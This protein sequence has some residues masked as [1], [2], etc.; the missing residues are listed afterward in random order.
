VKR[1]IVV[2]LCLFAAAC[3][4]APTN[5]PTPTSTPS[6]A[7]VDESQAVRA[8]F[9][10]YT[11]AALA[12]DGTTAVSVMA[13]PAFAFFDDMRKLALTATEQELATQKLST[14]L[15]AYTMRGGMDP[16]IVRTA[17]PQDLV[18][19][20]IDKGLVGEQGI[21]NLELGEVTVKG[22]TADVEVMSR[23]KKAPFTLRFAREDGRWKFDMLPLLEL[24]DAAF[25]SLAQEKNMTPE[26]LVEQVLITMYG[27]EKAA[28][29]RKPLGA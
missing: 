22:D 23:G 6:S 28:E 13:S 2:A 5:T 18:K 12:K 17:S 29:V 27:P 25:G 21:K 9:D 16:A 24:T 8:A 20:A 19:G 3:T 14:R 26:Q 1:L 11:K 15:M 10:T 4:Q 7:P